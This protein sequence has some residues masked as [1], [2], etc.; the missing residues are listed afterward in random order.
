MSTKTLAAIDLETTGLTPGV[1]GI[2]SIGFSHRKREKQ[3]LVWPHHGAVLSPRAIEINGYSPQRWHELGA[4]ELP[5]A[6]SE[7]NDL[8]KKLGYIHPLAHNAEFDSRWL[9]WAE[10]YTGIPHPFH[11]RWQCSQA[12]M[13]FAM[14]IGAIPHGSCSLDS[15]A[16]LAGLSRV[17]SQHIAGEDATITRNAYIW[18]MRQCNPLNLIRRRLSRF[19]SDSIPSFIS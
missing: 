7:L 14:H 10:S 15:L 2:V 16:A 12:A 19:F 9:N 4:V 5:V 18:L 11:T 8:C 13:A 6:L 1:H 17:S 3:W